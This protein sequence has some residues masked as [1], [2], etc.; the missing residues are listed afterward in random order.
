MENDDVIVQPVCGAVV[1]CTAD[2]GDP[3]AVIDELP[4]RCPYSCLVRAELR[5][6]ASIGQLQMLGMLTWQSWDG[7]PAVMTLRIVFIWCGLLC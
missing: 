2:F 4:D 5:R 7:S 3:F 1:G 6:S